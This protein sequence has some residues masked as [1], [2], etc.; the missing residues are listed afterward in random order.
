MMLNKFANTGSA[1]SGGIRN[2][3]VG[4]LNGLRRIVKTG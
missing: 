1:V 3:L 4:G 2:T